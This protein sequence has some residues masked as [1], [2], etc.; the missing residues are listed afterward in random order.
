MTNEE[1]SEGKVVKADP[2]LRPLDILAG[3]WEIEIV[4]S[5]FPRPVHGTATFEWFQ[6]GKFLI[7]R[8]RM[9][10]P[11]FPTFIA[12]IGYNET[13]GDYTQYYFDSRGVIRTYQVSLRDNTLKIWR[14]DPDFPQRFT[15]TFSG[16]GD[17]ITGRWEKAMDGLNWEHDFDLTFRRK[18]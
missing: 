3:A 18:K 1:S 12:V 10:D 5:L 7:E 2:K 15:G 11:I 14:E 6:G 8:S 9:D 13:A 4:H 16:D 17:T